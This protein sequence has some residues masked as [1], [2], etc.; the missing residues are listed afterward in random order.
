MTRR[1]PNLASGVPTLPELDL[2]PHQSTFTTLAGIS[3]T[4]ASTR[5]SRTNF[6]TLLEP[7]SCEMDSG[8]TRPRAC[9]NSAALVQATFAPGGAWSK[10]RADSRLDGI[11]ASRSTSTWRV[12]TG[13]D[14]VRISEPLT[15]SFRVVSIRDVQDFSGR[16]I[17]R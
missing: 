5:A 3:K 2:G 16:A 8:L 15:H 17:R 11:P 14:R 4:Q 1:T 12:G 10:H 9:T 13:T 7:G 6:V